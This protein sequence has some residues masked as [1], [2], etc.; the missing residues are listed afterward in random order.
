MVEI[1][2][3]LTVFGTAAAPGRRGNSV[4]EKSKHRKNNRD[5]RPYR[6]ITACVSAG[7][8]IDVEQKMQWCLAIV[9]RSGLDEDHMEKFECGLRREVEARRIGE[10]KLSKARTCVSK[11]SNSQRRRKCK[12]RMNKT[13]RLALRR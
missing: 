13:R 11:K 6:Q 1:F 5:P 12:A 4:G 9:R 7:T 2:E 3:H 10:A 8:D